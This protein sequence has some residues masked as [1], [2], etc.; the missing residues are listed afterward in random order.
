MNANRSN[1]DLDALA[2]RLRGLPEPPVPA[3][4][5]AR[6][7]A[8]IPAA[9]V[10]VPRPRRQLRWGWL[11]LAGVLTAAAVLLA[12][13]LGYYFGKTDAPPDGPRGPPAPPLA[14]EPAPTLWNYRL[15]QYDSSGHD[16]SH[17]DPLPSAFEWPVQLTV[18]VAAHRLPDDFTD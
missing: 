13:F 7:L 2:D 9:G 18:P 10:F 16:T 3:G 11:P 8:A 14:V 12:I 5:E 1:D 6:L 17:A 15:A 4:L